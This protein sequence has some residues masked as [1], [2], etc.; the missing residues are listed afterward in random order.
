MRVAATACPSSMCSSS[1][2]TLWYN[3]TIVRL[4]CVILVT[5]IIHDQPALGLPELTT[6]EGNVTSLARR[7]M[8]LRI[9]CIILFGAVLR[10]V[11]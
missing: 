11:M 3:T 9:S 5:W 10:E 2:T 7:C 1:R 4:L 6:V 8:M